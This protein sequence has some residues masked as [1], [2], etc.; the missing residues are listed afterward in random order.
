ML[1]EFSADAGGSTPQ[2]ALPP[3]QTKASMQ[4]RYA[5]N[6]KLHIKQLITQLQGLQGGG[7]DLAV[8]IGE[9][10]KHLSE[11]D[12]AIA[13]GSPDAMLHSS[14]SAV[15]FY[16]QHYAA[17]MEEA[18]KLEGEAKEEALEAT[19]ALNHA[20]QIEQTRNF[21]QQYNIGNLKDY[22]QETQDYVTGNTARMFRDDPKLRP[23]WDMQQDIQ[24]I[25]QRN[26]RFAQ[27]IE[28]QKK[29]AKK[30]LDHINDEAKQKWDDETQ[31]YL[32]NIEDM[33]GKDRIPPK[34]IGL[35]REYKQ[36]PDPE[37]YQTLKQEVKEVHDATRTAV[38]EIFMRGYARMDGGLKE[39]IEKHL[40]A[41]GKEVNAENLQAV[42][43]GMKDK[44]TPENVN[45]ITHKLQSHGGKMSA[46]TEEERLTLAATQLNFNAEAG[47]T[48]YSLACHIRDMTPE[49]RKEFDKEMKELYD[50][51]NVEGVVALLEKSGLKST[52]SREEGAVLGF[53]MQNIGFDTMQQIIGENIK[54]INLLEAGDTEGAARISKEISSIYR[55]EINQKIAEATGGRTLTEEERENL[56]RGFNT[57][58]LSE[59]YGGCADI[60][61]TQICP[62]SGEEKDRLK[63][64]DISALLQSGVGW[65]SCPASPESET[66]TLSDVKSP[67]STPTNEG[68][69]AVRA[70]ASLP[71]KG[72]G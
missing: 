13:S 45:P 66:L 59:A 71:P 63:M 33:M 69:E 49:R 15:Q 31:A 68:T 27:A 36:H 11:I 39:A 70:N 20:A 3:S 58:L 42:V 16:A 32:H 12:A 55:E 30:A 52:G 14:D 47:K 46:L 40:Q 65:L 7:S 37:T 44:L 23:M 41:E 34:L 10:G 62:L 53:H 17:I 8:A 56:L 35:M 43:K 1:E 64:Y 51:H 50:K 24:A 9:L 26:P 38:D 2:E 5:E 29:E 25:M 67:A 19:E 54:K 61:P 57:S 4:Q 6:V 72:S 21:M 18:S 48:I 28:D 60:I 22:S